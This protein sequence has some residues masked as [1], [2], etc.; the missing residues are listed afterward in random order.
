ML[1][2]LPNAEDT[3]TTPLN[4]PFVPFSIPY[5][6]EK[7]ATEH[8][9]YLWAADMTLMFV[10]SER[11]LGS[12]LR[13]HQDLRPYIHNGTRGNNGNALNTFIA[14]NH[15]WGQIYLKFFFSIRRDFGALLHAKKDPAPIPST[16]SP[17]TSVQ[18]V[19]LSTAYTRYDRGE[20][21]FS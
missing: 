19:N 18:G 6:Y 2:S 1:R 7:V 21:L 20:P 14:G 5:N 12:A 17:K 16:L 8:T 13:L 3:P 15:F 11:F 4:S 9:R 10:L